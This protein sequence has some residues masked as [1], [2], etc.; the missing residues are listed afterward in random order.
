MS[1]HAQTAK[2]RTQRQTS[3]GPDEAGPP[4]QIAQNQNAVR[5]AVIN[6]HFA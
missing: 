1:V 2:R 4:Q 5:Q 6:S 3:I